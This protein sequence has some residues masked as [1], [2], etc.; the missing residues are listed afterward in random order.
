M[1][2][3]VGCNP[4]EE[5][6]PPPGTPTVVKTTPADG[7]MGFDRDASIKA[8][9]SEKMKKST[10]NRATFHI[11][12]GNFTCEQVNSPS[13]PPPPGFGTKVTYNDKKKIAT[14]NPFVRLAAG[15]TYTV[16]VEG[17]GDD[18]GF[19]VRD[20]AGSA[21]ATGKIFHFTTGRR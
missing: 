8:R 4:D 21:M 5:P 9:F 16:V 13:N 14:L 18:D 3:D 17:A 11:Y 2:G 6:P 7:R 12:W 15:T 20:R 10:V 1:P 19:A